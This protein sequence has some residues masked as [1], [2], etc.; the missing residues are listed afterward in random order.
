MKEKEARAKFRQVR[1]VFTV[2]YRSLPVAWRRGLA[3]VRN[4]ALQL[5]GFPITGAVGCGTW[6]LLPRAWRCP[7]RGAAG[8]H[9]LLI[10]LSRRSD[11]SPLVMSH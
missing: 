1:S 8:V 10:D 11:T 6:A 2:C 5:V 4:L 7:R 9:S 3:G